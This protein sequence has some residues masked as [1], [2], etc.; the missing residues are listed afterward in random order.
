M[1]DMV[2]MSGFEAEDAGG[3]AMGY[4]FGRRS[5]ESR[6]PLP[7]RFDRNGSFSIKPG[8]GPAEA[9]HRLAWR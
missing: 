2:R 8:N 5:P 9:A 4:R 6:L 1:A 7:I 3:D